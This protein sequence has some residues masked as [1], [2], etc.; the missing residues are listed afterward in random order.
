MGVMGPMCGIPFSE[1]LTV[2]DPSEVLRVRLSSKYFK[3]YQYCRTVSLL[4]DTPLTQ[5][6]NCF[7]LH[8]GKSLLSTHSTEL[9]AESTRSRTVSIFSLKVSMR[10]QVPCRNFYNGTF[11]FV[12][13]SYLRPAGRRSDSCYH[14]SISTEVPPN[15]HPSRLQKSTTVTVQLS[16]YCTRLLAL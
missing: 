14:S 4:I 16:W 6:A 1:H 11:V 7:N 10:S 8:F 5:V 9:A 12:A 15:K 3:Q 2:A 13:T